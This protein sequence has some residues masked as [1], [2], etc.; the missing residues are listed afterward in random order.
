MKKIRIAVAYHKKGIFANNEMFIPVHV[1]AALAKQELGIQKDSDG[2]N[3]SCFNPYCCELSATYW[4]WKNVEA[5]YYGLCH[6][7]RFFSHKKPSLGSSIVPNI[8]YWS[9]KAISPFVVDARFTV[10]KSGGMPQIEE[11]MLKG[12]LNSFSPWLQNRLD[13]E[14]IDCMCLKK[15]KMSTYSCKT[16]LM[17]AIGLYNFN[18]LEQI[19]RE[20]HPSFYPYFEKTMRDNAYNPCNMLIASK[21]VFDEYAH[22]LFSI[23]GEYH[24]WI[25]LGNTDVVNNAALRASGYMG[26]FITS[27]FIMQLKEQ[28]KSVMEMNEQDI[29]V[30]STGLSQTTDSICHRIK[31]VLLGNSGGVNLDNLIVFDIE[32]RHISSV[33]YREERRAA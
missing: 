9:S 33:S 28:G 8:V 17:K 10:G 24:H 23:L 2:D 26:E 30:A 11:P 20:K 14:E 16:K 15:I 31:N 18:K 13:S 4:L 21:S 25:T 32:C 1:G 5:D 19:I 27:A 29:A 6:Y 3:I 7:R 12:F 22:L